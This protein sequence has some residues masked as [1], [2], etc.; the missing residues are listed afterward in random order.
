VVTE[1]EYL[2]E[3][4]YGHEVAKV[5]FSHVPT[6][7]FRGL[8]IVWAEDFSVGTKAIGN[9]RAARHSD[10]GIARGNHDSDTLQAELEDLVALTSLIGYGQVVLLLTVLFLESVVVLQK[11][12]KWRGR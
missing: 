6:L 4:M 1:Y 7:C 2:P 3:V 11:S 10:A 8:T 9:V 12:M 5:E